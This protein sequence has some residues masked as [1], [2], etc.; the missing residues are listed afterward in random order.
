MLAIFMKHKLVFIFITKLFAFLFL[1][2]LV[3]CATPM[4]QFNEA[5]KLLSDGKTVEAKIVLN[6]I[7]AQDYGAGCSVLGGVLHQEQQND[8]QKYYQKGCDLK[9]GLGCFGL[10]SIQ[11]RKRENENFSKNI[12]LSCSY[13][14]QEACRVVEK[15]KSDN[16]EAKTKR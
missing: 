4:S 5:Q 12:N 2:L 1:T 14:F 15:I 16:L 9:D 10:A 8:Y 13:G 6:R 7:C 3:A 11:Y